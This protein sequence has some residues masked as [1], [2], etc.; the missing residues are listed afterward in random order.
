MSKSIYIIAYI[1]LIRFLMIQ[2]C[3]LFLKQQIAQKEALYCHIMDLQIMS[4]N[5][6]KALHLRCH[7]YRYSNG[8]ISLMDFKQPVGMHLKED[9]RWVKKAQIIL[10]II[11]N[12]AKNVAYGFQ[13]RL[14]AD[15]RK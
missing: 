7:M 12:I 2:Y 3:F 9:N 11:F 1:I 15:R 5:R 8:Q 6:A 10:G 13:D 14:S 4:E